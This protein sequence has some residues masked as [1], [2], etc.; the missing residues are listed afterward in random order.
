MLLWPQVKAAGVCICECFSKRAYHFNKSLTSTCCESSLGWSCVGGPAGCWSIPVTATSFQY[1]PG[2]TLFFMGS[3]FVLTL[4]SLLY[5]QSF[6]HPPSSPLYSSLSSFL[7]LSLSLSIPI[8]CVGCLSVSET[9][10]TESCVSGLIT[11]R[12]WETGSSQTST[13]VSSFVGHVRHSPDI[14]WRLLGF[15][16][17]LVW[18]CGPCGSLRGREAKGDTFYRYGYEVERHKTEE[19]SLAQ[20]VVKWIIFFPAVWWISISFHWKLS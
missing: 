11:P 1:L 6:S 8:S 7:S 10:Q 2:I 5:H 9:K 16:C 18:P 19:K 3:V 13:A 4:I 15:F 12:S 14:S 20:A 17:V